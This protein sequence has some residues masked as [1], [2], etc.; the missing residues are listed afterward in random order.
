MIAFED[1]AYGEIVLHPP[2]LSYL[3]TMMIPFLL[4]PWLMQYIA[5]GFSY[6]MHW[7]E[8]LFFMLGFLIFEMF[9]AP[10]AYIKVWAN[11]LLNSLGALRTICNSLLWAVI[12]LPMTFFLVIRDL[13]YL[14]MILCKHQGCRH[15][16]PDDLSEIEI[17]PD[18]RELLYNETRCTVIALYKRLQRHIN[19]EGN[20]IEQ[21]EEEEELME[22]VDVF[23]IM[24]DDSLNE[25]FLYVVKKSLILDEWRKRC[26]LAER[27]KRIEAKS[28]FKMSN[29]KN[30]LEQAF[31]KK[32][33]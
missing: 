15:G 7:L 3:S 11:V 20:V 28:I 23:T 14:I 8:N 27:R 1:K 26:F 24:N 22:D 12:G 4:S 10:L 16:K 2:P 29:L 21:A 25:D 30:R 32:Y 9:L 18:Q 5:K 19:Q 17:D 33:E 31:K 6:L 13:A